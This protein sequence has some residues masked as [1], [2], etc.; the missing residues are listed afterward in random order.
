M[1]FIPPTIYS[2]CSLGCSA[3]PFKHRSTSTSK[4]LN[5]ICP[6][7]PQRM[8][9]YLKA[10]IM[11]CGW[12]RQTLS[13]SYFLR[14]FSFVLRLDPSL[15]WSV[16]KN[17]GGNTDSILNR[18]LYLVAIIIII[19]SLCFTLGFHMWQQ[20]TAMTSASH[21]QMSQFNRY[22]FNKACYIFRSSFLSSRDS[23][24]Y[25]EFGL[26]ANEPFPCA[27]YMI[28]FCHASTLGFIIY[29]SETKLSSHF[30]PTSFLRHM[31]W[32]FFF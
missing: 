6:Y 17:R 18:L 13:L 5:C 25:S 21:W 22:I 16:N 28:C 2:G 1:T 20:I 31:F 27:E 30:V 8:T 19:T 14:C 29:P 7:S 24:K 11:W 26:F 3:L 10:I 9:H 32:L 15:S 23:N 12:C 4:H